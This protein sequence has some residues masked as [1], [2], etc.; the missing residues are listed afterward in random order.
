MKINYV[1]IIYRASINLRSD[2]IM[3]GA[4]CVYDE[5]HDEI[6]DTMISRE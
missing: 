5:A 4:V 1:A 6:F 2:A 3:I